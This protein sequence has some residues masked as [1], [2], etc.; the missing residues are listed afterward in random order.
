MRAERMKSIKNLLATKSK[1]GM[2]TNTNLS[3]KRTVRTIFNMAECQRN[4]LYQIY[5]DNF[6]A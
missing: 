3:E 6:L 5:V 2:K 1:A 4:T